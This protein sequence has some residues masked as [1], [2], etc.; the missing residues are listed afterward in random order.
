MKTGPELRRA[1]LRILFAMVIFA[2]LLALV[3]VLLMRA[4]VKAQT[5]AEDA[6]ISFRFAA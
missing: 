3:C 1:N 4:K 6:Q 2:L 5:A